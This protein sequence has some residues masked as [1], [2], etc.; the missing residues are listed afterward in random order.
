M[1]L[2]CLNIPDLLI[3]L[4]RGTFTHAVTDDPSLWPWAV[5]KGDV[6]KQHGQA[7]ADTLQYIPGS[8]DRPPRNPAEKIN[9]GYKAWE[10]LLYFFCM[11]PALL[12]GIL[13]MPYWRNYCKCAR[14]FLLLMQL[15]IPREDLTESYQLLVEFSD[16]Y[17]ELYYQ[18]RE[19]R[20]HFVRPCIHT[21]T[22]FP[23]ETERIGP[24]IVY[25]QWAIERMIGSL[26]LEL[27]QPLNMFSNFEQR[28]VR[29]CHVNALEA[30]ISD[31]REPEVIIPRGGLDLHDGYVLLG[32]KDNCE[33]AVRLSE[34]E[35]IQ[36]W[37]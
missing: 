9:S 33:R 17:E 1:H 25:A 21:M 23:R 2:P 6:W 32:A 22:H 4:W 30:L 10:Y 36:K 15:V 19:D 24:G 27:R 5:L 12:Y 28:G 7:V 31:L 3:P 14:G 11:G 18:R 29:R 37:V 20:I 35:A 34:L 16:E 26:G 13:P 8:F